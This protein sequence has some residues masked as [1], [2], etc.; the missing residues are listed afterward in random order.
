MDVLVISAIYLP[1]TIDMYK[2][3]WPA[4]PLPVAVCR[5]VEWTK[6]WSRLIFVVE[7]IASLFQPGTKTVNESAGNILSSAHIQYDYFYDLQLDWWHTNRSA[8]AQVVKPNQLCFVDH[9]CL[10]NHLITRHLST[11]S[12]CIRIWNNGTFF[13]FCFWQIPTKQTESICLARRADTNK[14]EGLTQ[15]NCHW[16]PNQGPQY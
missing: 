14:R 5:K 6:V 15:V 1:P 16:H 13:T 3:Y 11:N 2:R 8:W 10:V 12:T 4:M 9:L 7:V